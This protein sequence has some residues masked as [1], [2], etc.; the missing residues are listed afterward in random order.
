VGVAPQPT[1]IVSSG[2][3]WDLIELDVVGRSDDKKITVN[4]AK[5]KFFTIV[6]GLAMTVRIWSVRE[7]NW[8]WTGKEVVG[9]Y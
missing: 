8:G 4:S 5:E 9:G 7:G 3:L 6:V 2:H 1:V